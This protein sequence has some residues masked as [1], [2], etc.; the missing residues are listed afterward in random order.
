MATP[1]AALTPSKLRDELITH[2]LMLCIGSLSL[3]TFMSQS[4]YGTIDWR[5]VSGIIADSVDL[6]SYLAPSPLLLLPSLSRFSFVWLPT[7]LLSEWTT[8]LTRS[9]C[10]CTH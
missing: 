6:R 2:P 10:K 1:F 4:I 9:R 5:P 7:F 3:S 8:I